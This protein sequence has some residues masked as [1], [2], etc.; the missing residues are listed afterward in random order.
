MKLLSSIEAKSDEPGNVRDHRLNI[1]TRHEPLR[2]LYFDGSI[3]KLP[4]RKM[5][6]KRT[7]TSKQNMQTLVEEPVSKYIEH[8]TRNFWIS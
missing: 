6:Q 3:K 7:K 5:G 8:V 1:T 2:A 4:T